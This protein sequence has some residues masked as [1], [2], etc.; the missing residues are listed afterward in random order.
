M[1]CSESRTGLLPA[2][3]GRERTY[4]AAAAAAVA[5]KTKSLRSF[6]RARRRSRRRRRNRSHRRQTRRQSLHHRR[7][8]GRRRLLHD[9]TRPSW[10]SPPSTS[11]LGPTRRGDWPCFDEGLCFSPRESEKE[12]KKKERKSGTAET[13]SRIKMGAGG[14][15]EEENGAAAA[16]APSSSSLPA[17]AR[18]GEPAKL[19]CPKCLEFSLP[20][21]PS[22]FCSQDCF[23]VIR[24]C[25]RIG[26]FFVFQSS[27]QTAKRFPS[28]P[29]LN[30]DLF[31]S[32]SP[33]LP[34]RTQKNRPRGPSTRPRT[35][36]TR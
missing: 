7:G 30:L 15:K 32:F 22:C 34:L 4:L 8:G 27:R 21:H 18:C 24:S 31:L 23:K 5:P 33:P 1:L 20:K 29:L 19:Q 6:R 36:Q 25:E 17:C 11:P 3:R 28:S 2:R 14:G 13:Q 10:P 26:V 9:R 16:S 35:S 12:G